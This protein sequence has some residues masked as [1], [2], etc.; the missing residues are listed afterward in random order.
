M[1]DSK[2]LNFYNYLTLK[3]NSDHQINWFFYIT[4]LS[5]ITKK[6]DLQYSKLIMRLIRLESGANSRKQSHTHCLY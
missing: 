5:R 1:Y 2:D 4:K 3:Y 6:K